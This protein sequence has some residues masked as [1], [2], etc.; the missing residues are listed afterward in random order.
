M[1]SG[2]TQSFAD[3]AHRC[4]ALSACLTF[5]RRLPEHVRITVDMCQCT[6]K[7]REN[8]EYPTPPWCSHL[9]VLY[10]DIVDLPDA[11][12]RLCRCQGNGHDVRHAG[13]YARRAVPGAAQDPRPHRAEDLLRCVCSNPPHWTPPM[14]R[15]CSARAS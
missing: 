2:T 13:I 14:Q 1:A 7:K 10:R 6:V 8:A 11:E 4:A 3:I 5:F 12:P 15:H 9:T